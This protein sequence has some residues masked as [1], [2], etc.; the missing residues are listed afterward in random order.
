MSIYILAFIHLLFSSAPN[1]SNFSKKADTFLKTYV[2]EGKVDYSSIKNQETLNDLVNTIGL[3]KTE[4]LNA[5]EKAA[6][7]INSYNILTI[8]SVVTHYPIK[9]P[10]DV[11][12]FFDVQKHLVGG[13]QLTLNDIENI[14]IRKE[15]NDARIHFA[16]VCAGLG[17][18][19]L[20][21][22]AFTAENVDS[23]LNELT[24]AAL[25]SDFI[26]VDYSNKKIEISQI[27]QWYQ[28]DFGKNIDDSIEFINQYRDKKIPLDFEKGYY[29]YDWNLNSK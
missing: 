25:N 21:N 12:G 10:L 8:Q 11:E 13:E 22:E 27:F 20:T 7:Y 3:I 9:S 15:M 4:D 5:N 19:P 17:C 2:S 1:S 16:L 24:K 18:P 23:K 14:K 6:F 29:E 28:K 26:K